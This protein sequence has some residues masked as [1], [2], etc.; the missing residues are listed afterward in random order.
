MKY[1]IAIAVMC[2]VFALTSTVHALEVIVNETASAMI[3]PNPIPDATRGG[4]CY[5]SNV[6][7]AIINN[8]NPVNLIAGYPVVGLLLYYFD[9]SAYTG[10]V[11]SGDADL[12]IGQ[13][14]GDKTRPDYWCYTFECLSNWEETVVT[15]QNWL[16]PG[17]TNNPSFTNNFHK[18]FSEQISSCNLNLGDSGDIIYHWTIPS[19]VVQ[20]WLD[21]PA[22]NRGIAH[23]PDGSFNKM[24]WN[25]AR[26]NVFPLKIPR[27]TVNFVSNNQAPTTP[28]NLTPAN[29]AI[30]VPQTGARLS[31]SAFNDPNGDAFSNSQWQ[32]SADATFANILWDSGTIGP[33]TS[34]TIAATLQHSTRYYW[35]VRYRDGNVTEGQEWSA[36]SMPTSFDTVLNLIYPVA[37]IESMSAMAKNGSVYA[38]SNVTGRTEGTFNFVTAATNV[39]PAGFLMYWFDL[40]VFSMYT[41]MVVGGTPKLQVSS[42][43][44]WPQNPPI[45]DLRVLQAPWHESNITWNSYV[46]NDWGTWTGKVGE[47]VSSVTIDSGETAA[48]FEW[49]VPVSVI[50]QWIEN[51]N[52]NYGLALVPQGACNAMLYTRKS[53][54]PP[55]LVFDLAY[56]GAPAPAKPTNLSP[57]NGAADQSLTPTLTSSAYSGGAP[58]AASQWQLSEAG[59]MSPVKWD[60]GSSTGNLLSVSVP[61]AAGLTNNSRYYWRVRHVSSEGGKSPWSDVTSFDTPLVHGTF[62]KAATRMAMINYRAPGSN[63]NGNVS[64][65]FWPHTGSS[66]GINGAVILCRF[67]LD[68]FSGKGAE[69]GGDGE[70][71]VRWLYVNEDFGAIFFSAFPLLSPWDEDTVTWGTYVGA[72]PDLTNVIGET[73]GSQQVIAPGSPGGENGTTWTVPQDVIQT[74]LDSAASNFG[75]AF[76]PDQANANAI[77]HGKLAPGTAPK[78]TAEIIPEPAS[79]LLLGIAGVLGLLRR[80]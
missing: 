23:R 2:G 12:S 26:I 27:L 77:M 4:G 7:P 32:V 79:L 8:Y 16:G 55:T 64:T 5:V 42:M 49:E 38:N 52:Q 61:A 18:Y 54:R 25:R 47:V 71:N 78:L 57:A 46:G 21:D 60:S 39:A 19:N 41:G 63:V 48:T 80:R 24:L 62:T 29:A 76:Y 35:R 58:H 73:F 9:L 69:A 37:R 75:V 51:P 59:S 30:A 6:N 20:R 72:G 34:V 43:W 11:V 40:S 68:V 74:W 1:A 56:S 66:N 53:V 28:T 15:W 33:V 36:W 13:V 67:N 3:K 50:Q 70:V 17:M 14:W 65:V 45:F 22:S 10:R 44:A 31:A